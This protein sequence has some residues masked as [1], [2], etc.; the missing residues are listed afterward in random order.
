MPLRKA[1]ETK[2]EVKTFLI[3]ATC[4]KCGDGNMIYNGETFRVYT[5]SHM[6]LCDSRTCSHMEEYEIKYPHTSYENV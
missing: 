5:T 3:N 4:P 1:I 6:H 2:K